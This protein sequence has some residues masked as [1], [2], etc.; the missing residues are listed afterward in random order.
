M[1]VA[2]AILS[3]LL[4]FSLMLNARYARLCDRWSSLLKRR[5]REHLQFCKSMMKFLE[6]Q[7][8]LDGTVRWMEARSRSKETERSQ[9]A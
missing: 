2:V 9:I 4:V 6:L 8:F 7:K 5:E 3:V 1:I